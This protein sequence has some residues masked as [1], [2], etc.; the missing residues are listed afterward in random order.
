MNDY[1]S[2]QRRWSKQHEYEPMVAAAFKRALDCLCCSDDKYEPM[3]V[4]WAEVASVPS[5]LS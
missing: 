1:R 3:D 2:I 5:L 4:W